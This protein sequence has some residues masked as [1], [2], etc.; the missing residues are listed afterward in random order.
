M[1]I[2]MPLFFSSFINSFFMNVIELFQK[3]SIEQ[4]VLYFIILCVISMKSYSYRFIRGYQTLFCLSLI[5]YRAYYYEYYQQHSLLEIL[6]TSMKVFIA[7]PKVEFIIYDSLGV[8]LFIL[9]ITVIVHVLNYDYYHLNKHVPEYL[10]GL[11]QNTSMVQKILT[12]EQSKLENE[13]E[14]SLKTK[15]RQLGRY[16]QCSKA[17][18]IKE[19]VTYRMYCHSLSISPLCI[20]NDYFYHHHHY[21]YYRSLSALRLFLLTALLYD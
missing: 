8:L 13:F 12:K 7:N 18:R 2:E 6:L 5:S 17:C 21:D 9:I 3:L 14:H 4:R 11:V 19:V 10:Y 16:I 1:M 20:H 15:S